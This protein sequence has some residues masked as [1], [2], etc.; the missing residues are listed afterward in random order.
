VSRQAAIE[1]VEKYQAH[2]NKL[3]YIYGDPAGRA[4]EKHGH[5]SDYVEIEDYLRLHGWRFERRVS[6]AAPAIKDR[7]NAVRA[8]ILNAAG[9]VSLFVNP[10]V[11][12]YCHKGLSTVQVKSGSS[13]QEDQTNKFQHITT[14][15]G[16]FIYY[17]W[18]KG[19]RPMSST[20][21][22]GAT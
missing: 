16:Y 13:F 3:V 21:T 20:A 6:P 5:K 22:V 2:K 4:G 1:F 18:P 14:A 19:S 7:Q 17:L 9:E 11:A 8:K 15:I 12:K 10:K